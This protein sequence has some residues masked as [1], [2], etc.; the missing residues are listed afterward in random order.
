MASQVEFTPNGIPIPPQRRTASDR[1]RE[2]ANLNPGRY[3]PYVRVSDP[4][5][6][7]SGLSL[8]TQ[9]IRLAQYFV[10]AL[11]PKGV[12]WEGQFHIDAAVS[13]WKTPLFTRQTVQSMDPQPGDHVA[14]ASYDRLTRSL[15]CYTDIKSR[16]LDRHV[17]VHMLDI[18]IDTSTPAGQM[19]FAVVA[20]VA[21]QESRRKS[22]RMTEV[23]ETRR[24]A[25][26]P[27]NGKKPWGF[28]RAGTNGH[29]HLESDP[30]ELH[31]MEQVAHQFLLGC[32]AARVAEIM[33]LDQATCARGPWNR[34]TT[35]RAYNAWKELRQ[36]L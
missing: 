7:R 30:T 11:L 10:H 33:N 24:Q 27:V 20:M 28:R 29:Y 6:E 23:N 26:R 14:A 36:A 18:G 9:Q 1:L 31:V 4:K 25:G 34:Y 13:A 3:L 17:H 12:I 15:K 22:Q 19:V 16:W 35:R 21:E 2:Q 32:D 8:E 5:Q